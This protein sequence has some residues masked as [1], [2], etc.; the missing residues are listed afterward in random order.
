MNSVP[1]WVGRWPEAFSIVTGFFPETRPKD[2]KLKCRPL[3]VTQV[4]RRKSD[5]QIHLRV[6]YGTSKLRFPDRAGR[7]LIVQNIS[8]MNE[9]GLMTPTRFVVAPN[10]QII[11]PWTAEHFQ[12]WGA[13][14]T[15]RRG[16]L[17]D[18]LIHEYAWLMVQHLKSD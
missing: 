11:R 3:L 13:S 4:L 17:P 2:G 10:D 12:P 1:E 14:G 8:D 9:C 16:R 7:D 6:A 5:N 18:S 15:P